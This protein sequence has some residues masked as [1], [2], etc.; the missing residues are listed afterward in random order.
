[1]E[2]EEEK[3]EIHESV[4]VRNGGDLDTDLRFSAE[5][6][7]DEGSPRDV[8]FRPSEPASADQ[9]SEPIGI[10]RY[11]V[12]PVDLTVRTAELEGLTLPL[13][14]FSWSRVQRRLAEKR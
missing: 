10:S 13:K 7:D 4:V 8:T 9:T 2:V 6:W 1:L 11:S 12:A 5:L 3:T 14:G